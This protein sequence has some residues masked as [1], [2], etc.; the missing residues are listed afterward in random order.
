MEPQT[1]PPM[2]RIQVI[3]EQLSRQRF[4][5]C[6]KLRELLEVRSERTVLR[7]IGFMRDR[8]HLPIAYDATRR[9]YHY[10]RPVEALPLPMHLVSEAE[11]FAMLVA[12][13]AIAQYRGTPYHRPLTRAFHKLAAHLDAGERLH[14]Q[15]LDE[16]LD[17]RLSGPDELDE[18]TFDILARAIQQHRPLRFGYRKHAQRS[19]E[20]RRLHPYQFA[21]V[22]NRWYLLGHD[23]TRKA[24][25]VFVI[26]RISQPEILPG[27]F[28]RPTDFNCQ[29]Y[30][31]RSFGIFRGEDDFEVVIDLDPW[32]ADV[33]RGRRWHAS[34]QIQELPGG[35]LRV[36]FLLDNLAEIEP[37]VLSWGAHATVIRPQ[38]LAAAV[39][40]TATALLE[41]YVDPPARPNP[42][43]EPHLFR[44]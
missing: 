26:A 24:I 11:L 42:S 22:N 30:L 27:T 7:D 3:H 20:T 39:T 32:A 19:R 12:G 13:K 23:V 37:W 38:Q 44:V 9:G 5:N 36:T 33:L 8:L 6:A 21:C 25:R 15:S 4:P 10:T 18:E 28:E 2:E 17:I 35:E 29:E 14:L 1:R 16:A 40:R 41:R 31:R 34:Q 43:G